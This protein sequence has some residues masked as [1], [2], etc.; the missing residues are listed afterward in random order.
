MGIFYLFFTWKAA[1][2]E[3]APR[4]PSKE[5]WSGAYSGAL[6][7]LVDLSICAFTF[8]SVSLNFLLFIF[9]FSLDESE[10][11]ESAALRMFQMRHEWGEQF[12][13][14]CGDFEQLGSGVVSHHLREA[15]HSYPH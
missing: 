10:I 4:F 11:F 14:M 15:A 7:L 13:P 1:K 6:A 5:A 12:R 2:S 8:T 3:P 9:L